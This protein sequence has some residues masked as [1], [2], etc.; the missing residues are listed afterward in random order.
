M[1]RVREGSALLASTTRRRPVAYLHATSMNLRID[2]SYL[3][4]ARG[5]SL[6]RGWCLINS[7]SDFDSVPAVLF[8]KQWRQYDCVMIMG[9]LWSTVLK[10]RWMLT[11]NDWMLVSSSP[12]ITGVV[13]ETV[14][15]DCFIFCFLFLCCQ[16]CC[17][18]IFISPPGQNRKTKTTKK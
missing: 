6:A 3:L 1:P 10:S 7:N 14:R 16:L 12:V 11:L 15:S 4:A 18:W 13:L 8:Q 9:D 5:S 2:N 17:Y